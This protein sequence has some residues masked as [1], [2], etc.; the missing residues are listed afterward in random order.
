M[1]EDF[2]SAVLVAAVQLALIADESA[3]PP[4]V[5]PKNA[6][7]PLD[8]K[9]SVLQR[10]S[11]S[12]GLLPLLRV[13]RVIPALPPHPVIMA[14]RAADHPLDLLQRWS[15]LERFAHSRHRVMVCDSD[16]HSAVLQHVGPAGAIPLPEEDAVVLGVLIGL[17]VDIG[18]DGLTAGLD[19]DTVIFSDGAFL[20]PPVGRDLSRWWL[21]WS[22]RRPPH[23]A[24][25]DHGDTSL[26]DLARQMVVYDPARRWTVADVA[27]A[28]AVSTR[29]LQRQLQPSGGFAAL[30]GAT[31]A[32]V[33][34]ELLVTTD[35]PLGAIGFVC[36][37]S[38]QPHFSRDFKRR[39]GFTPAAYRAAFRRSAYSERPGS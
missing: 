2:A 24:A 7:L 4:T 10:V 23:A 37:Y 16:R 1:V 25:Q 17:L 3:A 6:L 33:A 5:I 39:S 30:L 22:G 12:Q 21:R 8:T 15:R 19:P 14:L 11:R 20:A 38:D 31:R 9:R 26:P 27:S 36:G 32:A 28:L 18:T 29:H 13:G 35:H 34:G